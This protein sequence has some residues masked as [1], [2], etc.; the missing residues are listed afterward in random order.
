MKILSVQEAQTISTKSEE[1]RKKRARDLEDEIDVLTRRFVRT[2]TECAEESARLTSELI[3]HERTTK[4]RKS[5]LT[6]EVESLEARRREALKPIDEMR[7]EA[8]EK[9]KVL[10][11]REQEIEKNEQIL[12]DREHAVLDHLEA[13]SDREGQIGKKELDIENRF[14][15]VE[16]EEARLR[17]LGEGL[18]KKWGKYHQTVYSAN[19]DLERRE[20]EVENVRQAN[21]SFKKSLDQIAEQQAKEWRAIK[22]GYATLQRAQDEILGKRS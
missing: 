3:E 9:M 20:R 22:D 10:E 13:L 12:L 19:Q 18:S 15:A 5:F 17:S 4:E 8:Q 14:A 16:I 6:Q 2:Q 1:A 7:V 11:A 21:E